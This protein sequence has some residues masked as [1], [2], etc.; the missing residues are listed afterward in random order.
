[1]NNNG[2]VV[3]EEINRVSPVVP[4]YGRE[5]MTTLGIGAAVGLLVAGAY[6]LLE[7]YVFAAV[8]CRAGADASCYQAPEYA[9]IVAMVIGAIIGLLALIQARVF[10]PL[11]VVLATVIS[12]WGMS[13]LMNDYA[14]YWQLLIAVGFFAGTYL[15]Y[16]WI[17]RTRSFLVAS[18]ITIALVVLMR[19]IIMS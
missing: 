17:A 12:L 11:L 10:R 3:S 16:S 2:G 19:F 9:M 7:K 13:S 14:W 5:V 15:L 6:V 18:I 1:M 8:L 4:T